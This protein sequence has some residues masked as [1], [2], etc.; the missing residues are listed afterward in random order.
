MKKK[1][2]KTCLLLHMLPAV[3]VAQPLATRLS[4]AWQKF[5][6]DPQLKYA[7]ISLTVL[8]T[9]TGETVFTKNGN[10]GLAPASTLKTIVSATAFHVLGPGFTY[11]TTLGY[12]G[13]IDGK[14]TLTGDVIITGG[15]DP[16]L[17]SWRYTASREQAILKRW[18]EAIRSAGIKK[19]AGR[20]ISDDRLFGTQT[21]PPGWIWQD[22][23]NY[24]GAGPASLTWRENQFDL[25]FSPGSKVGSP[26]SLVKTDPKFPYLTIVN[27]VITGP[28]GSGDNVY[29]YSSPYT[30][31]I[32]LRGSYGIDLKK[33]I[34]ASVPDPALEAAG[35]LMDTLSLAGIPVQSVTT[36]RILSMEK[37]S[38]VPPA[39]LVDTYTSPTLAQIIYWYNQKSINLYG[40]HLVKAIAQQLGKEITTPAGAS[41]VVAFWNTK[42]GIDK[43]ALNMID[44]S[45]L[46]PGTRVTTTAM[47]QILA[48]AKKEPW[49]A[50]Y[51][52]SLPTYNNMK[53]KS[54]SINDVLAYAGYETNNGTPLAFSFI[55]NNYNGSSAAVKQKMFNVLDLLK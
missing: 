4:A 19:I 21:L 43:N 36:A 48:S 32:Y 26:V 38:F 53:M 5:E 34:S 22:I 17:G 27:E 3:L 54:G 46:S 6:A 47:A 9:N 45:G 30:N 35:R 41:A 10:T 15:G 39:R 37:K 25:V 29:A 8:N 14:G 55:I 7:S 52:E 23:G 50:S 28:A 40:E 44:G 2:L 13:S 16:T 33:V 42:L 31:I 24:Y 51:F 20:I 12:S 11:Q 1:L 49:F 18:T